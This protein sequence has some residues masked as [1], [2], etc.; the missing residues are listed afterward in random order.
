MNW[1]LRNHSVKGRVLDIG[2]GEE[3]SYFNFLNAEKAHII[4]IDF[5][6]RG[7]L[8]VD[9][10][11]DVL[12]F[13]NGQADYVLMFNILEHIYNYHFLVTECHRVLKK[14]GEALG[15]VPFLINYHPDPH[16]YFR[17]TKEALF[18]IFSSNHF[19]VKEIR[20][21]G[22]GPLAVNYNNLA[23]SLPKVL[24]ILIFPFY[25]FLDKL[26]LRFRPKASERYPLGYLFVLRKP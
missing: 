12:P 8:R 17:Y 20:E 10:E 15:F 23:P 11:K 21:V 3:P 13:E 1:E 2:G 24:R 4:N 5:K 7:G 6:N 18:K 25:Y 26:F 16:D 14:G 9:L 19:E 22:L